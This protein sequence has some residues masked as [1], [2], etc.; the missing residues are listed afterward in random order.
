[1]ASVQENINSIRA[2]YQVTDT[3]G[4]DIHAEEGRP[5]LLVTWVGRDARPYGRFTLARNWDSFKVKLLSLILI[6]KMK[7]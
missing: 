7:H 6:L 3:E 1:M 2:I 4:L 5:D